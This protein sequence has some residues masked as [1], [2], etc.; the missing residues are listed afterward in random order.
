MA[1]PQADEIR[2]DIMV[3]RLFPDFQPAQL[4]WSVH[5]RLVFWLVLE[6][7]I[8]LAGLAVHRP[9]LPQRLRSVQYLV[10]LGVF[11]GDGCRGRGFGLEDCDSRPRA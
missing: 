9:D 5:K 6:F 8:L 2:Y 3:E 1:P 10:E 4:L 7:G 11:L